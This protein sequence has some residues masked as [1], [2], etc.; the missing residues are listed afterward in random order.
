[1]TATRDRPLRFKIRRGYDIR[2]GGR[3]AQQVEDAPLVT[4]VGLVGADYPGLQLTPSV[5]V[6]DRVRLGQVVAHDREHR[7]IR[8][9]APGA[10]IVRQ[11]ERGRRRI[12]QSIVIELSG[13]ES[14][15]FPATA[16]AH[17]G[18]LPA[19]RVREL[20]L[21]SGLWTAFRQR[22]FPGV[23]D[24]ATRPR[25]LFVVAIDTEPHAPDPDVVVGTALQDFEDGLAVIASLTEG[26]VFLCRRPGS[27]IPA[28]YG[29]RVRVA[30][31][32]GPHPAG[33]AGTH[34]H[35]LSPA[36]R[37]RTN[38]HI[39]YQDVLA[40]G[41]FFTTGHLDVERIVSLA[42][43]MVAR[44][45]LLRTRLGADVEELV[46]GELH[47]GACRVI[48][49]SVLSGR[50]ATEWGRHLGR[51]H[52]QVSVLADSRQHRGRGP[53]TALHGT[54]T[55]HVPV[56]A[57]EGVMPLDILPSQL[58]QA[59]LAGDAETAEAL[60]CLELDEEDLALCTY[61]CP[62]KLEYG[63]AL[64]SVLEGLAAET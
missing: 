61:V 20:L 8:L 32:A 15:A 46:R 7:D 25:A 1:M 3:P 60:G 6:G 17:V 52:R 41:R 37:G 63:P 10:G 5:R 34:M 56:G 62:G 19:D 21:A 35:L 39:G 23:P 54:R 12:L 36:G 43:P 57:F 53:T 64:T 13:N 27:S 45:R 44:P 2:V 11:V 59:L 14:E 58:L 48:S 40:I 26:P 55:V 31:F 38:W 9:T 16:G 18:G 22:P 30:E 4:S 24:P 42:G 47:A 33:L 29:G 28:G 49:G 50:Q 51:Y